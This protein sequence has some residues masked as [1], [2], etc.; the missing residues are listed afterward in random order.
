M[1]L[2]EARLVDADL[3]VLGGLNEGVWPHLPDTGPWVSRPMR[4][5]LGMT[6]PERRIGLM[7]HDFVQAACARKS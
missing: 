1:G 4:A 3:M 5:Q 7:A 6:S 2:L